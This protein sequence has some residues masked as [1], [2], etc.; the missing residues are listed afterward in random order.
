[1]TPR[2][3]PEHL[4]AYRHLILAL[5]WLLIIGLLSLFFGGGYV[6]IVW[7]GWQIQTTASV[8]VL[9]ATVIGYLLSYLARRMVGVR[10]LG[11]VGTP[12]IEKLFS[13]P[14]TTLNAHQPLSSLE[15]LGYLWL[16]DNSAKSSNSPWL[17]TVSDQ[18][19]PSIEQFFSPDSVLMPII[20]AYQA[21]E[22]GD[23]EQAAQHLQQATA[24]PEL[25]Q[26]EQIR[27]LLAK[28]DLARSDIANQDHA[29]ALQQLTEL[30][31]SMQQQAVTVEQS[32]PTDQLD[33]ASSV[34]SPSRSPSALSAAIAQ[35]WTSLALRQPLLLLDLANLPTISCAQQQAWLQQLLPQLAQANAAQLAQLQQYYDYYINQPE[36][37]QYNACTKAWL[38]ILYRWPQDH[39]T[40]DMLERR[41]QLADQLLRL[42]FDPDVLTV[43]LQDQVQQADLDNSRFSQR[44]AALASLYPGQPSIALAQWHLLQASH[45]P[46]AAQLILDHWQQHADFSY[47]RLA[48]ALADQPEQLRDLNTIYQPY[49]P[50][51]LSSLS[52]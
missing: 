50:A 51:K 28:S 48:I 26:I 24:L 37:L 12:W 43:W 40:P 31:A 21:R 13:A 14:A 49:L 41:Q 25:V 8:L 29:Q 36:A 46:E 2:L 38:M 45:Q 52:D 19:Y 4:L 32:S 33:A 30:D 22:N 15:Q 5:V 20:L 16:L 17:A 1:M 23:L 7:L 44:V 34:S 39:L 27:L 6:M 11:R 35:L 10:T 47:L 3:L 9:L 42:E 18:K